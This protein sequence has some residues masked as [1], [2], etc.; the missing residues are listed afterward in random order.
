M[1]I[2]ENK[3][4]I[5]YTIGDEGFEQETLMY[6]AGK[7]DAA[8]G[9]LGTIVLPKP[10]EDVSIPKKQPDSVVFSYSNTKD[11]II[12][13][14]VV[15]I[16]MNRTEPGQP[17][18]CTV[19][20]L[21]P[22]VD[23]NWVPLIRDVTLVLP[24]PSGGSRTDP[25]PALRNPHGLAQAGD[26]LY[27]SDYENQHIVT[28]KKD[29][30]ESAADGKNLEVEV[31]DL[32]GDLL[33]EN[34]KGQGVIALGGKVYALFI[35]TDL[36]DPA[37]H[38]YSHLV[39][40]GI[41]GA[42]GV[43]SYEAK[44]LV[45]KNAQSII[46][47]VRKENDVD[48]V[49]LLIPAIGGE[50]YYNGTTNS[51]ESNISVMPALGDWSTTAYPSGTA[52]V[53]L[54]GDVYTI[55]DPAPDPLPTPTA[56]DIHAIGAA[57]RD[58]ASAVFILTQIYDN[59][60]KKAFWRLYETT[61]DDILE[62][63]TLRVEG[64]PLTLTQ[65][66]LSTE[67]EFEA[68]DGGVMVVPDP[69]FADNIYFWDIL[70]EQTLRNDDEEDRLWLLLGSPFLVTKAEAY[71]SPTLETPIVNPYAMFAG[72]GGVNVNS[73]DLT[74]E[75]LHQAQRE[76]SLKRGVRGSRLSISA[77]KAAAAT[78]AMTGTVAEEE[79]EK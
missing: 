40:L 45:G 1:A 55:P 17:S 54:T 14:R 77:G 67:V 65:A 69:E 13:L 15:L 41:D 56:Y 3:V 58:G 51:T 71:G 21:V 57:M 24:P 47:V 25:E 70:Y 26:T 76:V 6:I 64:M 32:E 63:L 72:F 27:F 46:P 18:T 78:T 43:L 44:I 7:E 10:A 75:T 9:N 11:N 50:Q 31:C 33:D 37:E 34:A 68:I 39:R 16:K 66:T 12:R 73:V 59:A 36:E 49:Y 60:A 2:R 23:D 74:I 8:K 38:G 5:T 19:T 42:T 52:P 79:E 62:L 35:S 22:E 4:L 30:L 61:V 53:A 48:V 28:V 20:V 29:V